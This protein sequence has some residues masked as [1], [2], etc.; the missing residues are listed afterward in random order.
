MIYY[1]LV[2]RLISGSYKISPLVSHTS[3]VRHIIHTLDYT[4]PLEGMEPGE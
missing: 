2:G 4:P 1:S 3:T